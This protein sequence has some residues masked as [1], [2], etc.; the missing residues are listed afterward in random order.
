MNLIFNGFIIEFSHNC[1]IDFELIHEITESYVIKNE[2]DA[3]DQM[4][5]ILN[6]PKEGEEEI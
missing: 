5:M 1:T 6:D 2:Q 3:E 4:K